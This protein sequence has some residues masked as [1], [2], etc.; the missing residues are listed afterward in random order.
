M[1]D[2]HNY[3]FEDNKEVKVKKELSSWNEAI[4]YA[5]HLI[6]NGSEKVSISNECKYLVH[7]EKSDV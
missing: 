5:K 1:I 3:I 7:V 4:K 2:M 6:S